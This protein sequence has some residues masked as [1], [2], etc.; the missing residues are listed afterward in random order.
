MNTR[1]M[2]KTICVCGVLLGILSLIFGFICAND[3]GYGW[4]RKEVY[5]GDAYTG[6]QNAAAQTASNVGDFM[7]RYNNQTCYAF[8]VA[9][10]GIILASVNAWCNYL[11]L[12]ERMK[13]NRP[14][15]VNT[16]S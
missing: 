11:T 16:N 2:K 6:I 1:K 12:E 10:I 8:I 5:G 3:N 9:G 14:E 15:E 4:V 7:V 13:D